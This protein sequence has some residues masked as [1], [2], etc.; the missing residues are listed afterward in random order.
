MTAPLP[1]WTPDQPLRAD[2]TDEQI[3]E[4]EDQ[5]GQ[6]WVKVAREFADACVEQ[7]TAALERIYGPIAA[8]LEALTHPY[9]LRPPEQPSGPI[10][11]SFWC[12]SCGM[13]RNCI[14]K[15]GDWVCGSSHI[16]AT[17]GPSSE[18]PSGWETDPKALQAC[19][20]MIVR[21]LGEAAGMGAVSTSNVAKDIV[22][23]IGN[24]KFATD[25]AES[26]ATFG[27]AV[28][29]CRGGEP[30]KIEVIDGEVVA[31]WSN[32]P[33][34]HTGIGH[35]DFLRDCTSQEPVCPH[36][37]TTGTTSY[38]ALAAEPAEQPTRQPDLKAAIEE[39]EIKRDQMQARE[40]VE[41]AKSIRN[42]NKGGA[43]T[44]AYGAAIMAYNDTL[45][46]LHALFPS[47]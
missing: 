19:A 21:L 40:T 43:Y 13:F 39:I 41:N 30:L 35:R 9:S 47:E 17:E 24:G 7:N 38:C 20:T 31:S 1:Q 42:R 3:R 27:R 22:T 45:A 16:V 15:N 11:K 29:G 46:I 23:Q 10:G 26:V 25:Y 4:R 8:E 28:A 14:R 18:Q 36:V 5:H 2:A 12:E 33:V 34:I 44:T 37:R 32:R 6:H